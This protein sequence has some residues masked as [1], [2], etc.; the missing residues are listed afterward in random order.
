MYASISVAVFLMLR[1]I[2]L[3]V[4]VDEA[5]YKQLNVKHAYGQRT[6]VH[7]SMHI[8]YERIHRLTGAEIKQQ[9][10]A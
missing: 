7:T 4:A 9:G 1:K 2:Y 10:I 5:A 8:L 6:T 3:D